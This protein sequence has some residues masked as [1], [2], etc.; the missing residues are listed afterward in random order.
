MPVEHDEWRGLLGSRGDPADGVL[1]IE[2]PL[3]QSSEGGSGVFLARASDG[4]RWWVKPENNFQSPKVVATEYLV[5]KLG[6]LIGAPTCEVRIAR[7]PDEIAGWEFRPG[8]TLEA[9]FAHASRDV[10]NA[11]L[12]R[13]LEHRQRDDNRRRHAGVFA[14]YDWCWGSDDQ[15]LYAQTDDLKLYSHDHGHYLPG[16]PNWSEFTLIGQVDEAHQPGHPADGLDRDAVE[17]FATRL[18]QLGRDDFIPIMRSVPSSWSVTD[19][20]LEAVG[21]FAERRAPAVAGRLRRI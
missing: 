17:E 12:M 1:L 5:G 2:Q 16:G 14:I 13:A 19:A 18:E 15:W 21:V 9:G 4:Q 6:H 8:A 10:E 11:Q 20:D 3:T 7:I